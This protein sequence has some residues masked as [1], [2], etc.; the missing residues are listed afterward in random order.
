MQTTVP[1]RIGA[2]APIS[3]RHG[4]NFA[5]TA[6]SL[7]QCQELVFFFLLIVIVSENFIKI[8]LGLY[9]ILS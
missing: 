5:C 8:L 1:M 7:K 2:L 4:L 3:S 9:I 6:K